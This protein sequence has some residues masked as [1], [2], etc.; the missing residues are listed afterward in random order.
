MQSNEKN[1][2]SGSYKYSYLGAV[3]PP[4][5][6]R[7]YNLICMSVGGN[8]DKFGNFVALDHKAGPLELTIQ[9][10]AVCQMEYE[11]VATGFKDMLLARHVNQDLLKVSKT[12]DW[13]NRP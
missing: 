8:F 2:P 11:K 7:Y 5:V 10:S 1:T 4:E 6:Q 12:I 9:Q 3:R 13:L